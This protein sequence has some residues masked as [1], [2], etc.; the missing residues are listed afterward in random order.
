MKERYS[1]SQG[2][3]E[4]MLITRERRAGRLRGT[5]I[6][7]VLG[8]LVLPQPRARPLC[9]GDFGLD[10]VEQQAHEGQTS[11][12][13]RQEGLQRH[14]GQEKGRRLGDGGA[15]E[16]HGAGGVVEPLVELREEGAHDEGAEEHRDDLHTGQRNRGQTLLMA[17]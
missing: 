14:V 17:Y 9:G 13:H 6:R 15:H 12:G 7:A 16:V 11:E 8:E 10:P 1:S 3:P 4:P 5:H 2:H